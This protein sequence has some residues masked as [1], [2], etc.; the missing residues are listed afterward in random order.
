MIQLIT[1]KIRDGNL[2][3]VFDLFKKLKLDAESKKVVTIN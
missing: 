3:E 1:E 2:D